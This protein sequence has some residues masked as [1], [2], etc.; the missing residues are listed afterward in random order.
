M[1]HIL[2]EIKRARKIINGQFEIVRHIT[3]NIYVIKYP[4]SFRHERMFEYFTHG[5]NAID[6]L[7][8]IER[9]NIDMN[10]IY[11]VKDPTGFYRRANIVQI[12]DKDLFRV[13]YVDEDED[14]IVSLSQIKYDALFEDLWAIYQLFELKIN[15]IRRNPAYEFGR[16][17]AIFQKYP[18]ET[19]VET[20]AV[21]AAANADINATNVE[22]N[23]ADEIYAIDESNLKDGASVKSNAENNAPREANAASEVN[24]E[25]G[26][27]L[28]AEANNSP[29][30]ANDENSVLAKVNIAY[31]DDSEISDNEP[32]TEIF[33]VD[34]NQ[35]DDNGEAVGEKF[36]AN[37]APAETV[38][39]ND[40]NV[41]E[42][43]KNEKA[44]AKIPAQNDVALPLPHTSQT[45]KKF[46]NFNN[47]YNKLLQKAKK[48]VKKE[49][50]I[51]KE[52]HI[53]YTSEE[54]SSDTSDSRDTI[55]LAIS[56]PSDKRNV[57]LDS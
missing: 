19:N 26:A 34:P 56:R 5:S 12:I 31:I 44:E 52:E 14:D 22:V 13:W 41:C 24:V 47:I 7:P 28:L 46:D 17:P 16:Y 33:H 27:D 21:V 55:E 43:E 11:L 23:A 57:L 1:A 54:E 3:E 45:E 48:H 18:G 4:S 2:D 30:E 42:R 53:V 8:S 37:D 38:D 6:I 10:I 40:E 35:N 15:V 39:A 51:E 25:T 9:N 49:R 50:K 29:R 36:V 20:G 32:D